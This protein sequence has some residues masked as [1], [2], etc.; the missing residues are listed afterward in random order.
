MSINI[1]II[2]FLN[3]QIDNIEETLLSL[4]LQTF[5]S[6]DLIIIHN[7]EI[8]KDLLALNYSNLEICYI[9][10]TKSLYL[11]LIKAINIARGK[12]IIP[13]DEYTM[14][15]P[16]YLQIS[17]EFMESHSLTDVCGCH[18]RYNNSD[19]L[20]IYSPPIDNFHIHYQLLFRNPIFIWSTVIKKEKL[21]EIIDDKSFEIYNTSNDINNCDLFYLIWVNLAIKNAYFRTIPLVL[22][23]YTNNY[24]FPLVSKETLLI[25]SS[26]FEHICDKIIATDNNYYTVLNSL[27]NFFNQGKLRFFNLIEITGTISKQIN[28]NQRNENSNFKKKILICMQHLGKGGA[29]KLLTDILNLFD[30]KKY[31]IDLLLLQTVGHYTK[32][33]P[34]EVCC[35][36]LAESELYLLSS[37]DVEIGF[38]EG[39]CTKYIAKRQSAAYKIAW[40]HIDLKK[41][42]WTK[43][44][45]EKG[46]ELKCYEKMDKIVFVSNDAKQQFNKI[47]E[48]PLGK[49][50]VIYNLINKNEIDRKKNEFIVDK[51]NNIILSTVGRFDPPK[52]YERLIPILSKL[53]NED[54]LSFEFWFIGE[55]QQ[56]EKLI[57]L[58]HEYNIVDSVHF[59]GFCENPYPYMDASD[60]F[61]SSSIVEGFSLV[62]AEALCLGKPIVSTKTAGPTEL[63]DSGKYGLLVDN[64]AIG[65]YEGLKTMIIDKNLRM[66][67]KAR[68][69][70][71][72]LIFDATKTMNTIYE[73]LG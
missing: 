39:I 36:S 3:S 51:K 27:I 23:E 1:S 18:V 15:L 4:N 58:T 64:S 25:Q 59:W 35:F 32:F 34:E 48:I 53:I 66:M 6:F 26:Y 68:A 7:N 10:P 17:Y 52:G 29:E 65:I 62:V 2:L 11:S 43:N 24:Y 60:I 72:A 45:F 9:H 54:N 38:L 40:V 73:I 13:I 41:Y 8:N 46:E 70:E 31:H 44:Y 30:Y 19:K 71:R 56:M 47:F 42:H 55:G 50:D 16:E 49:Q 14:L 67:F 33:V 63:L 21:L 69:L 5:K 22:S 57:A 37:Y 28:I 20:C 61:V 12:Y